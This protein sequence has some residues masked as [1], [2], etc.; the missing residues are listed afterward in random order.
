[1]ASTDTHGQY[2]KVKVSLK[3]SKLE[4]DLRNMWNNRQNWFYNQDPEHAY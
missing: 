4:L 3:L 2:Q 1:M